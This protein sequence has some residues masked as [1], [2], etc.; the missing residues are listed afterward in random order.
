M[1]KCLFYSHNEINQKNI[2]DLEAKFKKFKE[3]MKQNHYFDILDLSKNASFSEIKSRINHMIKVFHPDQYTDSNLKKISNE[4]LSY[5]N[6]VRETLFNEEKRKVYIQHIEKK[7]GVGLAHLFS[8][9]QKGKKGL[10]ESRIDFKEAFNI[11][12]P[13]KGETTLPE[14]VKLYYLWASLKRDSFTGTRSA[15]AF[16]DRMSVEVKCTA[17]YFFVRALYFLKKGDSDLAQR[18]LEKSLSVEENFFPARIELAQL[19]KN[20]SVFKKVFFKVS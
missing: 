19:K 13:I 16:L 3:K 1:S 14:D 9:Y 4:I 15:E 20:Q 7:E 10:L 17:L 11:L 6:E 12:E 2:E 5:L 8:E 18:Y